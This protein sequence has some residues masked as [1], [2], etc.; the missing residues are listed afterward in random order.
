MSSKVPRLS[1]NERTVRNED[2]YDIARCQG[3][4][5]FRAEVDLREILELLK[6]TTVPRLGSGGT[7]K[8]AMVEPDFPCALLLDASSMAASCVAWS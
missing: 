4:D 2:R 8:G 5:V 3:K 6:S 1:A 7:A